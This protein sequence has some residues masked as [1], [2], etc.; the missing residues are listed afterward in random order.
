[1]HSILS[2][3]EL[4]VLQYSSSSYAKRNKKWGF[5]EK[6]SL[7]Q[8]RCQL[9]FILKQKKIGRIISKRNDKKSYEGCNRGGQTNTL[10]IW[11][12]QPTTSC[13]SSNQQNFTNFHKPLVLS[14]VMMIYEKL[15]LIFTFSIENFPIFFI[16]CRIWAKDRIWMMK[17]KWMREKN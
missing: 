5:Y 10:L 9:N 11:A 16:Y 15:N 17:N 3:F 6:L 1:M 4:N 8:K 14:C 2:W 12:N 7:W 13:H